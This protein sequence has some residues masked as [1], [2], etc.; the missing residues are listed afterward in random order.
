[1]CSYICYAAVSGDESGNKILRIVDGALIHPVQSIVQGQLGSYLPTV[2]GENIAPIQ[3][4]NTL[5]VTVSDAGIARSDAKGQEVREGVER[6]GQR[7]AAKAPAVG[8]VCGG[9]WPL[10][11][12][13]REPA[14]RI[15]I[16]KHIQAGIAVIAT[17]AELVGAHSVG[18][19][20]IDVA[21]G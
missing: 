3:I 15:R 16:I 14:R 7:I 5:L 4:V 17:E 11:T 9:K 19:G 21:G 20:L 6:A 13:E 8:G 12:I 10:R 1:M 2:L 18:E